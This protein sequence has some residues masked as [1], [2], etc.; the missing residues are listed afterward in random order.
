MCQPMPRNCNCPPPVQIDARADEECSCDCPSA[1]ECACPPS[2]RRF[3]RTKVKCPNARICCP[4]PRQPPGPPCCCTECRPCL[5]PPCD[6][7]SSSTCRPATPQVKPCR[8]ASPCPPSSPCRP[9]RSSPCRKPAP[10]SPCRSSARSSS[11]G[12]SCCSP[13]RA[14]GQSSSTCD[15][16]GEVA[17]VTRGHG[18]DGERDCAG[19]ADRRS[20][21]RCAHDGKG[22]ADECRSCCSRNCAGEPF[23][24]SCDRPGEPGND[25]GR[26]PNVTQVA[27]GVDKS[28]SIDHR[29][30]DHLDHHLLLC[31]DATSPG[32]AAAVGAPGAHGTRG[33]SA[34]K[35]WPRRGSRRAVSPPGAAGNALPNVT[36]ARKSV[37]TP[38]VDRTP[39]GTN[40]LHA[41]LAAKR[42]VTSP[43]R[44]TPGRSGLGV[45]HPASR[46]SSKG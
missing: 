2:E 30:V 43:Y 28:L 11:R 16:N 27:T 31:A 7:C 1:P 21:C 41:R 26:A 25:E 13:S 5:P 10:P 20:R 32:N 35:A 29:Q 24:G 23:R 40:V 4:V 15:D 38:G 37:A 44:A 14:P 42:I 46:G 36:A 12:S 17:E 6:P 33:T 3:S 45:F 8:P 9:K 22:C 39:I 19:D 34:W 18:D